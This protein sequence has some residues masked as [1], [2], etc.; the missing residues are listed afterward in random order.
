[1]QTPAGRAVR[2][3]GRYNGEPAA[4]RRRRRPF[5]RSAYEMLP[6][7]AAEPSDTPSAVMTVERLNWLSRETSERACAGS[8]VVTYASVCATPAL[9]I[10]IAPK[11][12]MTNASAERIGG[13]AT[14]SA[15]AAGR[16]ICGSIIAIAM[17]STA[18][19]SRPRCAASAAKRIAARAIGMTFPDVNDVSPSDSTRTAHAT[20]IGWL[21]MRAN[22]HGGEHDGQRDYHPP[23]N[24]GHSK[25]DKGERIK[26]GER[27]GRIGRRNR[28]VFWRSIVRRRRTALTLVKRGCKVRIQSLALRERGAVVGAE[29]DH[30]PSARAVAVELAGKRQQRADDRQQESRTT[31]Q[32]LRSLARGR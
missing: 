19:P 25:R 5:R 8:T 1:M 32:S 16:A 4:A 10:E 28:D 15:A 13:K 22:A 3:P 14:K 17:A 23:Q 18:A 2:E 6:A 9:A 27:V 31:A 7:S 11:S 12:T 20:K 30:E 21:V 24:R 29:V 26:N